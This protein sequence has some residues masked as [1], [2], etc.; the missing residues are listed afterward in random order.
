MAHAQSSLGDSITGSAGLQ[1][2]FGSIRK[3]L[4]VSRAAV[5]GLP[6]VR[7]A[8]GACAAIRQR[9]SFTRV[10]LQRTRA[11]SKPN[12]CCDIFHSSTKHVRVGAAVRDS[13]IYR[14]VNT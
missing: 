8:D 5:N 1:S 2:M 13:K 7:W 11:A 6:A 10:S 12:H 14:G 3:P 4:R 9:S